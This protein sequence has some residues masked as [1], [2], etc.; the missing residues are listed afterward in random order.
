MGV[1]LLFSKERG[2]RRNRLDS[3]RRWGIICSYLTFLLS[4]VQLL[5]ITALICVGIT[6]IFLSM[7]PRFQPRTTNTLGTISTNYLHHLGRP[8]FD[9][10]QVM[11]A[12]SSLTVLLACVPLY[13]AI[14]SSC[15]NRLEPGRRKRFA[16]IL[17]AP[18][19]LFSLMQ[20]SSVGLYH[21]SFPRLTV[22]IVYYYYVYFQPRLLFGDVAALAANGNFWDYKLSPALRKV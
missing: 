15:P 12:I 13:N 9:L 21:L 19:A 16:A 4:A 1:V 5:V 7:P 20:I 22:D 3:T 17:A 14:L 8:R 2:R 6:G 10:A 11:V 18:L